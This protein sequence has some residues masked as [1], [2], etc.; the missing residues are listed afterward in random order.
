VCFDNALTRI[1]RV[2]VLLLDCTTQHDEQQYCDAAALPHIA[3][4]GDSYA[5]THIWV[6]V[7][8]CLFVVDVCV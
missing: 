2:C 1:P 5:A 3:A 7:V 8:A 4:R 6:S